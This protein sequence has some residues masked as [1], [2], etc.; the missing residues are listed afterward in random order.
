M[1]GLFIKPHPSFV[2]WYPPTPTH[3]NDVELLKMTTS[4]VCSKLV[5]PWYASCGDGVCS[6]EDLICVIF[7]QTSDHFVFMFII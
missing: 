1:R 2:P 4:T 6:A 5:Y 7:F 3:P